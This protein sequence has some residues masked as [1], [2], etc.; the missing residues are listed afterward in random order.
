[1]FEPF[2]RADLV[3]SAWKPFEEEHGSPEN[4]QR[5]NKI[6]PHKELAW[7]P[8]DLGGME[9]GVLLAI[10]FQPLLSDIYVFL[11]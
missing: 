5:V 9:E 4:L 2:Q 11:V 8:S 3:L 1:M 6:N 7:E 10:V